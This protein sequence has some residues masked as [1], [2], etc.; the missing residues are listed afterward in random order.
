[1]YCL[2]CGRKIAES[3]SFC[4]ECSRT[5][6]QP[7]QESPYLSTRIRLP[8]RRETPVKKPESRERKPE[9]PVRTRPKKLIAAVSVLSVLCAM[10]AALCGYG[11]VRYLG[12][13]QENGRSPV[14]AENLRLNEENRAYATQIEELQTLIDA[15]EEERDT[16]SRKLDA[17]QKKSDFIDAHVVFVENDGSNYYHSYDCE[18]FTKQSYWAYSTNLAVSQGY[19][20]CPDCQ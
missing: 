15:L 2:R 9:R 3:A 18:H 13:R 14:Q 5:V 7:L 8:D 10:L 6:N 4:D 16:L 12:W 19:T 11:V 17:L 1:M 20:P